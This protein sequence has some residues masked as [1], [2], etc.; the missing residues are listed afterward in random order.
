[1]CDI[2][3]RMRSIETRPSTRASGPPGQEWTPRAKAMCSRTFLRRRSNSCGFSNRRGSR[4]AAPGSDHHH[5]A[6][7]QVDAADGRGLA[8]QPE[9]LLTGLSIRSDSSMKP[10]IRLRS[11]RSC[12]WT[13]G[14]SPEHLQCG[15][16]QLG[17][18]LLSGGK[19]ER[20]RA[21][22]LDHLG[23][24]PVRIL[25]R[26]ERG[27]HV[28][29]G[30]APPVLDVVAELVVEPL[31]RVDADR[32]VVQGADPRAGTVGSQD[33]P[34]FL[35]VLLRHA[36]QVGDHQQWRTAWSIRR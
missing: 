36:E 21:D 23:G 32:L 9:S 17:G 4:L 35:V 25:R 6:G 31:Q 33:A 34:E 1:M 5:G 22:H 24:R 13:S 19:K 20:R 26:R 30:F 12:C 14:R 18:G 7:G 28:V 27:Q 16:E 15:A 29:A 11:S 8:G 2:R 10:G 3:S